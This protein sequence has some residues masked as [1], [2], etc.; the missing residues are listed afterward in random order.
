M[1]TTTWTAPA[2]ATAQIEVTIPAFKGLK[3]VAHFFAIA[4]G[5]TAANDT[6]FR[7]LDLNGNPMWAHG[8]DMRKN[9][10]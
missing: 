9:Q 5:A 2:P 10:F 1:T 4:C 6:E 8:S 3:K 7:G